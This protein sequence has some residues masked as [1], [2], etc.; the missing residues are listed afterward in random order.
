VPAAMTDDGVSISYEAAGQGPP[1]LL[2]IHGWGGSGRAFE[3]MLEH[4]D[5]TRGRAVTYD[6]RGHR[7]SDPADGGYTLDQLAA[8]ALS[9]ADAAGLDEFV[10][11][12]F[13]MGAKFG[14][15]LALVAP[16]RVA[17]LILLAGCPAGEIPLPAEL[18][19]DWYGRE[20]DAARM[21]EIALTYS[22]QPIDPEV[23]ARFGE[24]AA[25]VRRVALEGTLTACVDTSF[26]D[27]VGAI[28]A[29]ALVIGGLHDPMFT[30]ELMR[31]GVAAP[32]P[33]ARLAL[34]DAGHEIAMEAPRTLAALVEA[35]LAGLGGQAGVSPSAAASRP[36]ERMPSLR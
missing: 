34:L 21:A 35:F 20:G 19:D 12:G 8:D 13:S 23:L 30:P 28:A 15:Y 18:T 29:P 11:L 33:N 2:C 5:L 7:R 10:V 4:L 27:R 36:R 32:L 17:G 22:T 16:Q 25:M 1:D 6:L 9:V 26:A 24:D 3:P 31:E 14:Q